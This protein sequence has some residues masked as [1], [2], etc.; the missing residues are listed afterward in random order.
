ML[1]A[2]VDKPEA[3]R[4]LQVGDGNVRRA[5]EDSTAEV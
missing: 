5:I 2:G 1:K 3:M 4:R